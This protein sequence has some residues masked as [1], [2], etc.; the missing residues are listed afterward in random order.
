MQIALTKKL[1]DALGVK[2]SDT[3]EAENPLFCWTAN[4]TNVWDNRKTDDMLVLVNNATRFIVAVYQFKRK[5]LKNIKNAIREAIVNTLL[6]LNLNPEIVEDYL[7]QA[8]DL[9]FTANRNRQTTAWVVKAGLECAYYIGDRFNGSGKMY[10]DTIGASRNY[11][12]VNYS[13]KNS[14]AFYPYQA[15]FEALAKL[16]KKPAYKYRAFELMVT[17]DLDVYQAVRKIIVPADLKFTQFHRVLQDVFDWKNSHLYEFTVYAKGGERSGI[18]LVLEKDAMFPEDGDI[19][20]EDHSLSEYLPECETMRYTYDMGDSW[21]HEIRLLRVI[22]AYDQ[23]SPRQLEA[24]GQHPPEDVGGVPVFLNFRAVV[25]NP[26][27]PDYQEMKAWA[28][29]WTPELSAWQ[30]KPRAIHV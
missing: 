28:R 4:W 29:F 23:E 18:R 12:P 5:D 15:M 2:P 30:K 13:G 20:L 9:K 10:S 25:A 17:L 26:K 14:V 27:D 1:T 8:G 24:I 3:D 7:L 21:E 6:S 11:A 16:T 22:D 19:L